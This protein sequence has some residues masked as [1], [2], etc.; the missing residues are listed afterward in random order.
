MQRTLLIHWGQS[1]GGTRFHRDL[2]VA[3]VADSDA[4][5]SYNVASDQASAMGGL[6]SP[7][8]A[9]RTY[10]TKLGVIL[11]IPRL[12]ANL[13]R[14]RW[15]LRR[16]G[17]T[18]V[19]S[20]MESIYQSIAVPLVLPRRVTYVTVIHDASQHP[21]DEHVLKR[22]G[23]RL[24]LNRA[25]EVVVL[26]RAVADALIATGQTEPRQVRTLFHPAYGS[27]ASSP[28]TLPTDRA[29]TVGAFGRLMP[30][31]GIDLFV[32]AMNILRDGGVPV[33]GVV[34]GQGPEARLQHEP[35]GSSVVWRTE[36]IPD[37]EVDSLI[38]SFDIV[39][40]TY[41]EASQSG[42]VAQALA[43]GIPVVATPVGGLVEQVEGSGAGLI[44]ADIT[45]PSIARAIARLAT[46]AETYATLSRGAVTSAEALTW[47]RL[48]QELVR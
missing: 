42:V 25:D 41:R 26:S 39:A 4:V 32:D 38:R 30:Y 6:A 15:F 19:V 9:L 3:M 40:V 46:D 13:V 24:E 33:T 31:K 37:Q 7:A 43:A 44:A 2:A 11:G 5:V 34:A 1:G 21:G 17:V 12:V 16:H 14:L 29:V 10:R 47:E 8:F 35:R 27:T 22:L 18:R 23:R 20:S 45:P 28:R 48:A 36:W